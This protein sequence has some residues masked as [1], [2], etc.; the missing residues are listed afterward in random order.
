MIVSY[1]KRLGKPLSFEIGLADVADP[2][3][4]NERL[5]GVKPLTQWYND[6]L[7]SLILDCP[8]QYWWV[9]HRWKD[10]PRAR[11]TAEKQAR[12]AAAA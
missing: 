5:A 7:G 10:E 4:W 11:A 8:E 12:R 3:C 2:K 1:A 6:A 9:H